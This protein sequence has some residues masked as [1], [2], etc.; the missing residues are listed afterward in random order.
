MIKELIFDIENDTENL[1]V[2]EIKNYF[3][4][5][6]QA[7]KLYDGDY[8]ADWL[9]S[10]IHA[11]EWVLRTRR[12]TIK[13]NG[14]YKYAKRIKWDRFLSDETLLTDKKNKFIKELIQKLTFINFESP[15]S[16]NN[17]SIQSLFSIGIQTGVIISWLIF[18][19]DKLNTNKNGLTLLS[20]S[21]IEEL[22]K[23]MISGGTFELL[24]TGQRILEIIS[25]EINC[26][27]IGVDIFNLS[28]KNKQTIISYLND[29]GLY[30]YNYHRRLVI[31]RPVFYK[32]FKLSKQEM[33]SHK[34]T[35]FL[36]QFEPELLIYNSKVLIPA[37]FST[38]FPSHRTP[39]IS[40]IKLKKY[41]SS[42]VLQYLRI[43]QDWFSLKDMFHNELPNPEV[44]RFNEIRTYIK[45]QGI[46]NEVTPWIPIQT[47]MRLLNKSINLILDYG[48]ELTSF[49]QECEE[50]F[51]KNG[52]LGKEYYSQRNIYV[53]KN[54]PKN[55]KDLNITRFSRSNNVSFEENSNNNRYP[56]LRKE[57]SLKDMMSVLHGACILIIGGL[58][59]IRIGEL[60]DLK[61]ECIYFKKNDGFWMKQD[62]YK[63][64]TN[65]ILPTD[66]KPIPKITA[67]AIKLMQRFNSIA[68][69]C[70]PKS[71]KKETRYLFYGLNYNQTNLHA[72]IK[73]SE[74]IGKCIETFTDY[75]E[76]PLDSYGRRWYANIHELRK[77]FLLTFFWTFKFSSLDACRW[78]A[79]QKDPDHIFR[80]IEK[81]MPG[82]EMV[83]I[84]AEYASQQLKLF[85]TDYNLSEMENISSLNNDVCNHFN[86]KNTSEIPEE[87]LNEWIEV[88]LKK[89]TYSIEAFD[90]GSHK[91]IFQT[92]IAFR[93]SRK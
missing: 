73:D 2:I 74:Q 11:D 81:N 12:T 19:D 45:S 9:L 47:S 69:K 68:K 50:Y 49:Y 51:L 61:T 26:N 76:V 24:N 4:E 56:R 62:I 86:V 52:Y 28:E 44:F 64:G 67:E 79:G 8:T 32:K 55:L 16:N 90:I 78:M 36:R 54:I 85:N 91:D 37:E 35:L 31:N 33:H 14:T 13:E 27:V 72:S 21:W 88:S 30:K 15:L 66:E 22:S 93:I 87:E 57:P 34:A 43:I 7:I 83:E 17:S 40:E 59:P 77:S 42:Y 48:D 23:K 6:E 65:D 5:Y 71:N 29:K 38:E 92:R 70:N 84:E 89:G 63:S 82:E 53:E 20:Q 58:K 1:D 60:A 46:N 25:K 75:I 3:H 10:D 39:L 18:N 41:S 80:Y